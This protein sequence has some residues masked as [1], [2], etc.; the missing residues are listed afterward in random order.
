MNNCIYLALDKNYEKYA[1]PCLNSIFRNWPNHPKIFIYSN[2]NLSE[3]IKSCIANK[4]VEIRRFSPF[5]FNNLGPVGNNIV[6]TKYL[7]WSDEFKNY[8]NV[9]HLDCDI[10]VLQPLD[11]MFTAESLFISNNETLKSVKCFKSADIP[12]CNA[13]VFV[14]NSKHRNEINHVM[15]ISLTEEH[16]SDAC[17]ADQSIISL[18]CK[19]KNV[20]LSDNVYYN[21][22]PQFINYKS[23]TGDQIYSFDKIKIIHFAA[24]KPD[25]ISFH[26]WWRCDGWQHRYYD[27]WSKYK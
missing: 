14:V 8:D 5:K 21:F 12:M 24:R 4:N 6:Y 16:Q 13:G 9:L 22:Q 11:D 18:W 23:V 10:V 15:L 26:T 27:I 2:D 7:C 20:K 19:I 1:I 25:T 3:K 17:Y